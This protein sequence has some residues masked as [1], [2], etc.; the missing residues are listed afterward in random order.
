MHENSYRVFEKYAL[1]YFRLDMQVLEIGPDSSPNS[2]SHMS[3]RDLVSREYRLDYRFSDLMNKCKDSREFVTT[4]DD[5]GTIGACSDRFDI[6][7]SANVIEHVSAVWRWMSELARVTKPNGLVICIN[8][9]SWPYHEAPIDCWRLYPEAY[10]AL[11]DYTGLDHVFSW[12]GTLAPI[13]KH[14]EAEHGSQP[15]VDTIAIGRK[16]CR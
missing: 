14:W 15:V 11:F 9:V 10:K 6:V 13:D 1:P 7:F 2:D 3:L 12:Y 8:P 4:Y 16:P 5:G